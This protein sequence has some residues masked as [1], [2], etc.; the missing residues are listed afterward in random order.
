MRSGTLL[1]MPN[2]AFDLQ[3]ITCGMMAS[4]RRCRP[5]AGELLKERQLL[6][7]EQRQL[8]L[9]R[10]KA[11]AAIMVHNRSN[12]ICREER[13]ERSTTSRMIYPLG[14]GSTGYVKYWSYLQGFHFEADCK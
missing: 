12:A 8:I 7:E 1:A 4:D 10:N 2:T 5:S 3:T 13:R 14:D 6:S 9:E 11:T